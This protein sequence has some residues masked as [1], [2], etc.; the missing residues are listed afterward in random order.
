MKYL[1]FFLKLLYHIYAFVLFVGFMLI[2]LPFVAVAAIFGRVTGGNIISKLCRFW[3]NSI[4]FLAG[5]RQTNIYLAPHDTKKRYVFVSNHISYIDPP[6]I[7]KAI[8]N[9]N[10][11]IL[12]KYEMTKFPLFGFIY[13]NATVMVDRSSA[14]NR[15]KS[16]HQLKKVIAKNISIVIFPEG[17]FNET[18]KPLKKFFDGAFRIAIE[19]QTPIKPILL[20]DTHDRLDYKTLFSL[21]PGRSR[22]IFL[23]EIPVEGLTMKEVKVLKDKVH[24]AMEEKLLF[25]KA[26][27]IT[28]NK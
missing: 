2:V 9:Q 15:A 20:L 27:W 6:A 5:I 25:Y 7:I 11:R 14:R 19:T 12:G 21:N 3:A 17:T 18:N 13:R 1:L 4:F 24:K 8:S 26:D 23:D 10:F 22:V 16:I 28:H